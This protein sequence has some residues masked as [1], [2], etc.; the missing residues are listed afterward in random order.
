MS[1]RTSLLDKL[2][3]C[4]CH[5]PNPISGPA[6]HRGTVLDR[7]F[8]ARL[9]GQP[10]PE[11]D[12]F[13]ELSDEDF[14]AV[15]W[16][17][18]TLRAMAG[19]ETILAEEKECA[20]R[21]PGLPN[22]GTADAIVAGRHM[23]ADLKSGMLR[24]Y[25]YQ[26]A[27]YAY[28]LMET[29]FCDSWTAHLLFLDQRKLVTHSFTYAEAKAMVEDIVARYHAPDKTPTV[30][31]YCSWCIK[32]DT[33]PARLAEAEK[34]L[35]AAHPS[36]SIES[37]LSDNVRLGEFLSACAILDGYREQ[38]EATAKERLI[39]GHQVP[40]WTVSSRKGNEFVPPKE[41]KALIPRLGLSDLLAAMG[42]LSGKKL[43][44]L[45]Q[46]KCPEEPFPETLIRHCAMTISLRAVKSSSP[47]PSSPNPQLTTTN[48]PTNH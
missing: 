1:V 13:C 43:R 46:Q 20:V 3:L 44:H 9:L 48:P 5:A 36:F 45:W 15:D 30:N 16:A 31:E 4:S 29:H 35:A 32:K 10:D 27:G 41:L 14:D 26:M 22:P 21:V 33:C 28:G 47:R 34:A 40:G 6:A 39:A 11:P 38:A 17:V 25:T 7:V 19:G 37:I 2:L 23:H 18:T 8:R 42:N 24:S 12:P